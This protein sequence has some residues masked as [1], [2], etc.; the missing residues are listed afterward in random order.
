MLFLP[1]HAQV[2]YAG[3]RRK[4]AQGKMQ[5]G[6]R[7]T[8]GGS[9]QVCGPFRS[10]KVVREGLAG[11]M[12]LGEGFSIKS[13]LREVMGFAGHCR[14]LF[15]SGQAGSA[16]AS[17][18]DARPVGS[19]QVVRMITP[20]LIPQ[21]SITMFITSR[22]S[23]NGRWERYHLVVDL[24]RTSHLQAVRQ[25]PTPSLQRRTPLHTSAHPPKQQR[26]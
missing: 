6:G 2:A 13:G 24:I 26:P 15:R 5:R 19:W 11:R 14:G 23:V 12:D 10:E 20:S 1:R 22:R 21:Y 7:K 16:F 9:T 3:P 25:R 18:A 4:L 17:S 8:R